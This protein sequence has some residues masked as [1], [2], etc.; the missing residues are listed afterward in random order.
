MKKRYQVIILVVLL[1]AA[2]LIRAYR[3][4][5]TFA[6]S[7]EFGD[8]L[9]DIK[10]MY[11]SKQIPLLGPASSHPWLYFGPMYYWLMIPLLAVFNFNPL[12][13]AWFGVVAG[14]IVILLNYLVAKKVF[15]QKTTLISSVLISVS[16][17]WI[18]FSKDARFYFLSTLVFYPFLYFLYKFWKNQSN[19]FW[20]G[21][22][23]GLFFHFHYSPILLLPILLLVFFLKRKKIKFGKIIRFIGGLLISMFPVLLFD[24]K[25]GFKMTRSL[26]LWVPYRIAGFIGLYPKNNI[27]LPTF[28]KSLY[29]TIEFLGKSFVFEK[30]L[31]VP[32][33]L[34]LTIL[35]VYKLRIAIKQKGRNFANLFIIS[36]LFVSLLGVFVHG[37]SPIHYYFPI[38]PIPII[39]LSTFL[40]KVMIK[41]FK[42][43]LFVGLFGV[44]FLLNARSYSDFTS[45]LQNEKVFIEPHFISLDIQKEVAGFIIDDVKGEKYSLKRVG[46]Y[47]YFE[48]NYS[49]NYKYLLWLYGNEPVEKADLR[50]TIY[51][52]VTS[53]V[54]GEG[55]DVRKIN[56]LVVV[57][58]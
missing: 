47:D 7:G 44:L 12:V 49:Q 13:A 33:S 10:N 6:F 38:F 35:F 29:S 17:L 37:D 14:T 53:L 45:R 28:Q 27:S 20:L 1:L 15:T 16:P 26:I 19:V 43:G 48:E 54:V 46:P 57:K 30:S 5:D 52:D 9:L 32:I 8:N 22:F 42:G 21:F 40:E 18:S 3:L 24:F 11:I 23:F 41:S 31:W 34:L 56:N 51:E 2:F 4:K 39:L 58:E 25:S 50:Y 36:S 55:A